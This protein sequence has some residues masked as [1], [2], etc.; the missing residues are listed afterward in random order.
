MLS[1]LIIR[2]F[3]KNYLS[4]AGGTFL[5]DIYEMFLDITDIREK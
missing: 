3:I 5:M 4:L 1:N 2:K